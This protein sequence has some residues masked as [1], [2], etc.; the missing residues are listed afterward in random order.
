MRNKIKPKV[1]ILCITYKH[2]SFIR[3]TLNA[4]ITQETDFPFEILIGDDA[5]PDKT[6]EIVAEYANLFPAKIIPV[7]RKKNIGALRN[8]NHLISIADGDYF[9]YCEG[10][11]YWSDNKKLQKQADFLDENPDCTLCFHPVHQVF[12]DNSQPISIIDPFSFFDFSFT[13]RNYF[14]MK[15]LLSINFIASLSV[16]YRWQLGKSLPKWMLNHKMNGGKS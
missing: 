12:V 11:D 13:D 14:T 2:E 9:A 6:G 4:F 5:S 10:D 8:L 7:L 16:M 3:D 15:E 1:S